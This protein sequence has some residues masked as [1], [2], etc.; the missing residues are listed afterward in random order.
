[1]GEKLME[2]RRMATVQPPSALAVVD[3][4]TDQ[5]VIQ[6]VNAASTTSQ[7]LTEVPKQ[8][9]LRTNGRGCVPALCE[10]RRERVELRAD[11]P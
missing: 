1:M 4:R 2:R 10:M 6:L 8:V 3:K 5:F 7:P 11:D 9:E